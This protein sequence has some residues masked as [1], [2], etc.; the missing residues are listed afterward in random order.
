MPSY[1]TVITATGLR[2]APSTTLAAVVQ[3]LR[4]MLNDFSSLE[5]S[6]IPEHGEIEASDSNEVLRVSKDGLLTL[7]LTC[8]GKGHG[9]LPV[10]VERS[11]AQ[12]EALLAAAGTVTLYNED[13]TPYTEGAVMFRFLGATDRMRAIAKVN[14]G[15]AML[16][17]ML[18]GSL[19]PEQIE[20]LRHQGLTLLSSN[21]MEPEPSPRKAPAK[22]SARKPVRAT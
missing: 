9:Q 11:L 21:P 6:Q 17:D 2:L 4:P 5:L 8:E 3:A 1:R 22:S 20:S 10:T 14:N 13:V 12:L 19:T 16:K 7:V 15:F 18:Q